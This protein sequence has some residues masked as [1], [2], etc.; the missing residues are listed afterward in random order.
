LSAILGK[1]PREDEWPIG[2]GRAHLDEPGKKRRKLTLPA[3]EHPDINFL[4]T[5][6]VGGSMAPFPI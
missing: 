6:P 2:D 3:K 4:G 5:A 1:R